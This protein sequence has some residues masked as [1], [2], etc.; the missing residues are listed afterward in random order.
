M[1]IIGAQEISGKWGNQIQVVVQVVNGVQKS[2]IRGPEMHTVESATD[3]DAIIRQ[4][5]GIDDGGEL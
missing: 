5:M 2:A 1:R 3:K 4:M